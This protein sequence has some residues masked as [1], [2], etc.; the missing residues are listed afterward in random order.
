MAQFKYVTNKNIV[1]SNCD[2]IVNT[3]NC[4][5]VSGK[6]I[7]L[8][9]KNH[10]PDNF[11]KYKARCL[12]KRLKPGGHMFFKQRKGFRRIH[13][14]NVATKNKWH[15]NSEYKWIDNILKDIAN[16]LSD[17]SVK[18]IAIPPLGC[19]CGGLDWDIVHSMI[20]TKLEHCNQTIYIYGSNTNDKTSTF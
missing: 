1:H 4:S 5:G 8:D 14:L 13:I 6:G 11:N 20:L 17:N 9:F 10:Y 2:I 19:G 3:V 18:H 15:F 16:I 12:A 7:A